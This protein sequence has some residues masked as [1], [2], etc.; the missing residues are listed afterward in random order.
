MWNWYSLWKYPKKSL[1]DVVEG[2]QT[3]R[4]P[5]TGAEAPAIVLGVTDPQTCLVLRD[6]INALR[7]AGFRVTLISSPG[8][9]LLRFAY[10]EKIN[11]HAIPMRRGIAPLADLRAIYRLW[12]L[13]IRLRPDL[14][15]FSTPKAGLLGSIASLLSGTRVRVYLLRGLRLETAK[16]VTKRL[17]LWSERIAAACSHHVLCNSESLRD[18]ALKLRIA[19][20]QKLWLLGP[21]SSN[22][23][24]TER[25]HPGHPSPRPW[26]GIPPL[27]PVIGFVGRL[28]RDK[29][30]PELLVAFEQILAAVPLAY[31][32]L[33]GWFD[34]S[35]DALSEECRERIRCHPRII[36]TG[37]VADTAPLYRALD[38]LVLPTWREGFPNV[39]LEASASGIPVITTFSTGSRD[40]VVPEVTG[41]LIPPGH[42]KAIAESVLR[43]IRTPDLRYKMGRAARAWAQKRFQ[44]HKVLG[45]TVSFYDGLVRDCRPTSFPEAS[46]DPAIF[47]D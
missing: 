22:G 43:L 17:L 32:L 7:A 29:G 24:D 10:E 45:L 39:V 15:E 35:E 11:V 30:I 34:Q 6:R 18:M 5:E 14:T 40:A 13:L 4:N 41:L 47:A 20:A 31:L 16:G 27:V 44:N 42:A 25:F 37:L 23:V 3:R 46:E 9:L 33:V 19:P 38:I 1:L 8:P 12:R 2:L 26:L 21:G 36:T 28:T